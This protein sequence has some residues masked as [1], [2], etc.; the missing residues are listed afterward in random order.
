MILSLGEAI[1]RVSGRVYQ[2][3][4]FIGESLKQ[5]RNQVVDIYGAE[6]Y[7]VGDGG[8][9]ARFYI[10]VSPDMVYYNRFEFKLI[11]QPFVSTVGGGVTSAT[12]RVNDTSLNVNGTSLSPNPHTHSTDAHTH[13]VN[14]GV[15]LVPVVASNFRISVE[16]IDITSYLA[17]QHDSWITGEGVFPSIEIEKNYDLLEVA[18]DMEAEGR[19]VDVQALLKPGYKP[20]EISASG[21]FSCTM[22]LYLKYSH[23]NR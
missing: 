20:I 1:E 3:K 22:S 4:N 8:S 23:A 21:A 11:I 10:S 6:I 15:T 16:G 5:R 18:S 19:S 2:N 9:P 17:A 13:N 14:A 12:V 7:R